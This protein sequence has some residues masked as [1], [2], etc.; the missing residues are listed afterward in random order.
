[1][2]VRTRSLRIRRV[3]RIFPLVP[4][5]FLALGLGVTEGSAAETHGRAT[6][7]PGS[8]TLG[9]PVGSADPRVDVTRAERLEARADALADR[10]DRRAQAA[11]LYREAAG[12]RPAED[13]QRVANLRNAARMSFYAGQLPA[14]ERDAHEAS[15]AALRQGDLVEAAHAYLD[16]A[17]LAARRG[18]A[19]QAERWIEEARLLS[20]S[21]LLAQ[22]QQ[23]AIRSRMQQTG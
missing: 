2:F 6:L 22:A 3:R 17:W 10:M 1:M 7:A 5:V 12:L 4:A 20:A 21:P 8:M 11:R 18:Q 14:A 13:P 19:E 15:Q 9:A 23:E 16:A